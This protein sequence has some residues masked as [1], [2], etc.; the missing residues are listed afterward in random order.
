LK[1]AFLFAP[2][3]VGVIVLRDA[4]AYLV[5]FVIVFLSLTVW[6]AATSLRRCPHCG[7]LVFAGFGVSPVFLQRCPRCRKDLPGRRGRR[8]RDAGG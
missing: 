5:G 2:L 3:V 8:G 7:Y 1:L 4:P 6:V